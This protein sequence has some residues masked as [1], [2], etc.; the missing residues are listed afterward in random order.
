M[1]VFLRAYTPPNLSRPLAE[2]QAKVSPLMHNCIVAFSPMAGPEVK[3]L[4]TS[5]VSLPPS[6]HFCHFFL[7]S[8]QPPSMGASIDWGSIKEGDKHVPGHGA[9]IGLH[10]CHVSTTLNGPVMA[11]LFNSFCCSFY[12]SQLWRFS[13]HGFM[14][15]CTQWNKAVR[16]ILRLP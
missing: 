8:K 10:K 3:L 5:F 9:C 16:R 14:N 4:L 1:H 12:S 2:I 11:K 6:N 7:P 13:S 15:V